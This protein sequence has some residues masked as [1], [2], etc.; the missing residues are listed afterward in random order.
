MQEREREGRD[1]ARERGGEIMQERE[2]N[3]ARERER[4]KRLLKRKK[5]RVRS[6]PCVYLT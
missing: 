1:N 6:K 4:E 5:E 2:I 3:N